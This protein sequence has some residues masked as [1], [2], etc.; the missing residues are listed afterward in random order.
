MKTSTGEEKTKTVSQQPNKFSQLREGSYEHHS[1]YEA[2]G[3]SMKT[4]VKEEKA[5][6]FL[7]MVA[8]K[9]PDLLSKTPPF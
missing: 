6:T 8:A 1:Q 9:L 2:E 3:I 5:A 4:R 7:S